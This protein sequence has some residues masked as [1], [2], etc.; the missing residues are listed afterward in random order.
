MSSG[1]ALELILR[2]SGEHVR[3]QAEQALAPLAAYD[4]DHGG[5]LQRTLATY[6]ASGCNASRSA[7]ELY[8]H[9]SGLL[10]RLSRIESLL[11]VSLDSFE[12]R[13]ALSIAV[14]ARDRAR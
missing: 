9:R 5:D 12:V 6:L 2:A 3:S 13:T 7:A 11:G 8:L 1:E 10:Y 14:L 4:R